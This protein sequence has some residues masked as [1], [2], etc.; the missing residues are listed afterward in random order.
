MITAP[1]T[2]DFAPLPAGTYVARCFSMVHIGTV[3][4]NINNRPV[5]V[6][7]VRV[8]FET[9]NE[10]KEFKEGEG[11]KPYIVHKEFTLS[12]N[13]KASLRKMLESWRGKPFTD[14]EAGKFN[15]AKLIGVSCMITVIHKTSAAGNVRAEITAI[16]GLPK[17]FE[18]PPQVNPGFEFSHQEWDNE[19][20][21]KL[22][23]FLQNKIRSSVEYKMRFGEE[24][25]PAQQDAM[26]G[27]EFEK[28]IVIETGN[29]DVPF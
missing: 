22:P 19:K 13:K 16:T 26:Q 25:T 6:N 12:M 29:D 10:T 3:V 17:G 28:R 23:E 8:S 21:G 4:E 18:C 5:Q 20:F 2:S 14:E 27:A 24:F 9:P 1:V 7:K 15:I 11:Q